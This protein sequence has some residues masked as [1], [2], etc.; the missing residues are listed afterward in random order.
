[1]MTHIKTV[2][3]ASLSNEVDNVTQL[4]MIGKALSKLEGAV[5][6]VIFDPEATEESSEDG[7]M[8]ARVPWKGLPEKCYAQIDDYRGDTGKVLTIYK[9]S[10]R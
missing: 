5:D 2:F 1:M 3:T 4:K 10:E 8:T 7:G 9:A 6:L